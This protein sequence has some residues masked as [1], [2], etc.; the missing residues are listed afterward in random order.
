VR[1]SVPDAEV[2]QEESVSHSDITT[3][4]LSNSHSALLFF[5]SVVLSF[6]EILNRSIFKFL[7]HIT[8][9]RHE[10]HEEP[11]VSRVWLRW[12]ASAEDVVLG[13]LGAP[14]FQEGRQ[15]L[16]VHGLRQ[17]SQSRTSIQQHLLGKTH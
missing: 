14:C 1:P 13:V 5:V 16:V 12:S 6:L 11:R 2:L 10:F 8:S 7:C 9:L 4:M 17:V 15:D 3:A